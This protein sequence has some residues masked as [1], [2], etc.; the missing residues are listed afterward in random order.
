MTKPKEPPIPVSVNWST[1]ILSIPKG[2]WVNETRKTKKGTTT[3]KVWH[4][5]LLWLYVVANYYGTKQAV[6]TK[7]YWIP[8]KEHRDWDGGLIKIHPPRWCG[9]T[10][11]APPTILAWARYEEL[12]EGQ[13]KPLPPE[14]RKDVA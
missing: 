12:E 13:A 6:I 1:D 11:D 4:S 2:K 14:L 8:P 3:V 7:S 10:A 9:A 5:D